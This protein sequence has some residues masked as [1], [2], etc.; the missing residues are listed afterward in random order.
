MSQPTSTQHA[1]SSQEPIKKPLVSGTAVDRLKGLRYAPSPSGVDSNLLV[2]LHG[3]GDSS[4]PFF[5]LA[6]NLQST[7]PQTAVISLQAQHVVPFLDPGQHWMWW[8]TFDQFGEI[9]TKPD[10]TKTVADLVGLLAH[11]TNPIGSRSEQNA[12]HRGCGWDPKHIHL[13]G[14]GQGAT[15]ALETM[16]AWTRRYR[17]DRGPLG[18]VV[19]VSGD[20]VSHPSMDPPNPTPVLHVYRAAKPIPSDSS[21]FSSLR[22]ATASLQLQRLELAPGGTKEAM[23]RSKP[24]WDPIM[25]FWSKFFRHRG[26]W[27]LD[28]QVIPLS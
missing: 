18:S 2:M 28:G 17:S 15:A 24:E 14:F 8:S 10:P 23:P 27:E 26:K 7:L 25:S 3:L 11:L 19:S 21:R 16:V 5:N 1:E 13:F 20:L 4:T 22:K 9:L 6:Q 12:T